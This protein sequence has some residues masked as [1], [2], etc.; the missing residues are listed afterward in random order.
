MEECVR[1]PKTVNSMKTNQISFF[2]TAD[3]LR[4]IFE[5]TSKDIEY[6][7]T[8]IDGSEFPVAHE[9]VSSVPDFCVAHHG[10]ENF[11]AAYLLSPRGESVKTRRIETRSGNVKFILDQSINP[12]SVFVRPGG[13]LVDNNAIVSGKI[14]T[15]TNN[16]WSVMLFSILKK[17]IRKNFKACNSF[18][19]SDEAERLPDS[20]FRLT[21]SIRAPVEF[22][23]KK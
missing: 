14:G 23:F 5:R 18:F 3:E 6:C 7:I 19:L 15:I 22:A 9:G 11:E 17:S 12:R 13:L 20:G 21:Q 10:D 2:S 8:K 16:E 1:Y 4:S